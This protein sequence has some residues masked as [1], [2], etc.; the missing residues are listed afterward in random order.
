M[1]NNIRVSAGNNNTAN[2]TVSSTNINTPIKA[3]SV[4]AVYHANR[5]EE[6]AK[7]AQQSATDAQNAERNASNVVNNISTLTQDALN[8][9]NNATTESLSAIDDA[10]APVFEHLDTVQYISDNMNNVIYVAMNV[11]TILNKTID[12]GTVKT[13]E[14]GTNATVTNSGTQYNPV[15]NFTIP[16]GD[17]GEQGDNGKDGKDGDDGGMD[18]TYDEETKTLSFYNETGTFLHPKWGDVAG[19]INN[20]QDLIDKFKDY[21]THIDVLSAIASIPQ[22]KLSIVTKLPA[23]GEKMTLYLVPKEGTGSDV[24]NEYIWIEQTSRFEF[25]GTT[26]VDLT[27]YYTKTEIDSKI[28]DIE[29]ILD[30]INGDV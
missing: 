5:A 2:V 9:I 4:E 22:F 12:I 1:A 23:T 11:D 20:Q 29:S 10:S 8:D 28:G 17:K 21:A 6:Y 15:L 25:L 27:D 16:R 18:A 13:T 30:E 7:Q 19:D 26:A 3:T 14:A 24:H